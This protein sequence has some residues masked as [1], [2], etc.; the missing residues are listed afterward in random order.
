[1]RIDLTKNFFGIFSKRHHRKLHFIFFFTRWCIL[2]KE[3]SLIAKTFQQVLPGQRKLLTLLHTAKT[4]QLWIKKVYEGGEQMQFC[5]E[6]RKTNHL[7]DIKRLKNFWTVVY[8]ETCFP[9]G[10]FV[11]IKCALIIPWTWNLIRM[12][13]GKQKW[14][15]CTYIALL[16][17]LLSPC[18]IFLYVS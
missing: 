16:L 5:P 15:T 1:M 2:Y 8:G 4:S 7:Y 18:S 11:K 14:H 3:E 13:T 17:L 6:Y 10:G 12:M 9:G